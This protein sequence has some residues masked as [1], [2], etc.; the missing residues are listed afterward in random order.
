MRIPGFRAEASLKSAGKMREWRINSERKAGQADVLEIRPALLRS[1]QQ[2]RRDCDGD[3]N[4]LWVPN[5]RVRCGGFCAY[6]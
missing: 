5:P 6:W 3:P 2:L 1:C 4:N